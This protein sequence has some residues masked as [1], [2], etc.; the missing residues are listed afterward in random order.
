MAI[1][2]E[3]ALQG[4]HQPSAE[5]VVGSPSRFAIRDLTGRL[6]VSDDRS[7]KAGAQCVGK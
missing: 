2:L 5:G 7:V 1:P 6:L 4:Q 3:R